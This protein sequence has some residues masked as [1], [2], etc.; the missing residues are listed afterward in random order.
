MIEELRGTR[1]LRGFRGAPPADETALQH[2]LLRI[3]ELVDAAPE[4]QELDLNPV[5]VLSSGACVADA[6]IRVENAQRVRRGR[7]VEY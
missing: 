4:I 5:V 7:R 3:S 2:V 1:L 6:R